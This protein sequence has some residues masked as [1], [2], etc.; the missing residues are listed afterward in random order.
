ML[1]SS[2]TRKTGGAIPA[3]AAVGLEIAITR[4]EK[5]ASIEKFILLKPNS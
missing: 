3:K 5:I 4:M 2:M 1:S